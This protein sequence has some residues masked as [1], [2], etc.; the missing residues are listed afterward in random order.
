MQAVSIR[1]G[2]H[3]FVPIGLLFERKYAVSFVPS[4][5]TH[6]DDRGQNHVVAPSSRLRRR[7]GFWRSD[8][9][10]A[11]SRGGDSSLALPRGHG[12]RRD[13]NSVIGIGTCDPR[14]SEP[15]LKKRAVRKGA[16]PESHKAVGTDATVRPAHVTATTAHQSSFIESEPLSF[17]S[18]AHRPRHHKPPKNICKPTK[19]RSPNVN[20][21]ERSEM[22]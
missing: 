12:L 15:R 21:I 3:G 17:D 18:P 16:E 13:Q 5:V 9:K 10:A 19:N 6:P 14:R 22:V 8:F 7:M 4:E 20:P 11:E 2:P 1:R